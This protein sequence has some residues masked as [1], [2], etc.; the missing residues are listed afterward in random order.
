MIYIIKTQLIRIIRSKKLVGTLLFAPALFLFC[1]FNAD[2]ANFSASYVLILFAGLIAMLSSEILHWLTIDEIKDGIFDIMLISPL[3]KWRL[4]I[5]KLFVP[6]ATG[7]GMAF[8]TLFLNNLIT[9]YF[10][11]AVWQFSMWTTVLLLFSACFFAVLE[12]I[13]L[14]I[15]RKRNTS[16]H[17]FLLALGAC[18]TM[19][20]FY[21]IELHAYYVFIAI[22]TVLLASGVYALFRLLKSNQRI[23]SDK[24]RYVFPNLYSAANLSPLRAL[25]GKNLSVLRLYRFSALQLVTATLAPVLV[26]CLAFLQPNLPFDIFLI[27]SFAAIPCVS[28]IYLVFYSFLY[29][30]R[31]KAN[32]MLRIIGVTPIGSI[33]EKAVAAWIVSCALCVGCCMATSLFRPL[34]IRALLLMLA[35]SF[36]SS[37]I[38]GIL[39]FKVNSFK[40]ENIYKALI[41]VIVLAVHCIVVV[42][43]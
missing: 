26:A 9:R 24:Q 10:H 38:C 16:L 34:S 37:L 2:N 42:L 3:P 33:A 40:G 11:F 14:L 39:S 23:I 18:A 15:T 27:F 7:A 21:L 43:V 25:F 4:L 22:I 20:L 13:T 32:D 29:E 31:S 19:G 30:N 41:S 35:G 6:A 5:S 12:F 36:V 28:N 8:F 1:S 17:F